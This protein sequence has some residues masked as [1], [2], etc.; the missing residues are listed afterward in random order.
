MK[1]AILSLLAGLMGVGI[2]AAAPVGKILILDNE[3]LIEG[4]IRQQGDQYIVRRGMG[5]TIIPANKVI[6]LVADRKQAY[7]VMSERCNRHDIDDRVR[8]GRWCMENHFHDEAL[9]EAELL[10]QFRP[11]DEQIQRLAQG[12]RMLKAKEDEPAAVPSLPA[13]KPPEKVLDV[14]PPEYNRESFG[15]FVSK[16]QPILMNACARCHASGQGGNF[17]LMNVIDGGTRKT[18]LFN[19]TA[20]LKQLKR[21]DLANSPLL[22]KSVTAHG[23]ANQPP[24]RE[25][26][27]DW[28]SR[29]W[30]PGCKW[31]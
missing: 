10:L 27:G 19:L 17:E 29:I 30:K 11:K 18:A 22:I 16:V 2:A 21:N 24:F 4:D 3:L 7:R 9:A 8:P 5:E 20:T 26:A 12:L 23:K 31:R 25:P 14:E 13:T 15:T 6:E 28:P 1:I